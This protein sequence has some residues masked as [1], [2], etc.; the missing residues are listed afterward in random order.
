[1]W[2]NPFFGSV[3]LITDSKG[4]L[5]MARFQ[6]ISETEMDLFFKDKGFSHVLLEGTTEKV[7][8]KLVAPNTSLRIYSSIES[9]T[10][11]QC[12]EDAIRVVLATRNPS[13]IKI[14]GSSRRV[15]RTKNWRDNLQ[16][17]LDS[18]L[19]MLGPPCP[20]CGAAMVERSG[21][22]GE[23]WGCS[24]YPECKGLIKI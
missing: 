6:P 7:Y 5:K 12:G 8:A 11:R 14:V 3:K 4:G 24:N 19:E 1:M 10:S 15:N 17:R 13:G 2:A 22:Y 23:F 21:A 9:G 18:W 16:K 20:K